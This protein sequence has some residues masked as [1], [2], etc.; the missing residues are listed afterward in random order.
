[1]A[2]GTAV[3]VAVLVC[4]LGFWSVTW[5]AAV[6][7]LATCLAGLHGLHRLAHMTESHGAIGKIAK[8]RASIV[9]SLGRKHD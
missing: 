7:L 9:A 8:A 2:V 3:L 6:G 4:L 1:M 5:A